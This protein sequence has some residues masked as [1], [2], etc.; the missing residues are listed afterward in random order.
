V[1]IFLLLLL[2][3]Y[4]LLSQTPFPDSLVIAEQEMRSVQYEIGGGLLLPFKS[5]N[6]EGGTGGNLFLEVRSTTPISIRANVGWYSADTRIDYLSK[7]SSSFLYLELSILLRAMTGTLQPFGGLGIGFYSIDNSLDKEVIDFFNQLDFGVKEEIQGG[8][9]F[10]FRGGFDLL[11]ESN[12]GMF[13]EMKYWLYNPEA[14]STV[15]PL[16]HPSNE[17]EVSKEIELSNLNLILGLF[18]IL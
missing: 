14:T 13:M 8:A 9:G 15:Y 2:L 1:K 17:T 3:S 11:F 4:N 6:Y 16:D 12:F 7:G 10:H 5:K 18:I